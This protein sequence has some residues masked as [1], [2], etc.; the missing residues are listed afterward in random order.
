MEHK[1]AKVRRVPQEY[2]EYLLCRF[3]R[4]AGEVQGR[5]RMHKA[6]FLLGAQGLP[7]F[8][9]FFFHLRGPYSLALA[10]A[11]DR[12]VDQELIDEE[13]EQVGSDP[14]MVRYRYRLS[15]QG[16]KVLSRFESPPWSSHPMVGGAVS[17]GNNYAPRFLKLV[18]LKVRDLELAAAVTYWNQQGYSWEEA[19]HITAD[20]KRCSPEGQELAGAVRFA[21]GIVT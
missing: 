16:D 17:L 8:T 5:I 6:V 12:L 7:L 4:E 21:K 20:L 2:V 14:E 9:D 15:S 13:A 10:R 19:T 11:L 1:M 3:I 18:E